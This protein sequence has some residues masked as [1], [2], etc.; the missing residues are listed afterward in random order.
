MALSL[1]K[2][3]Q[4]RNFQETSEPEGQISQLQQNRFV[5]QEHWASHHHFDFRLEMEGV[6]RSWA[7]PKGLPEE[8][9]VKRLAVETEPHPLEYL[10]FEG[11]I[12]EGSYGAGRVEI[13]DQGKYV[14]KSQDS[15]AM[16]FELKGKKLKGLYHLVKM[17]DKNWLIFKDEKRTE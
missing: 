16:S 7:V 9:G 17:D 11:Q 5:I 8:T 10:N 3:K 13:Y 1:N 4:K 6:L 2:Y 15:K 12:P 14:L